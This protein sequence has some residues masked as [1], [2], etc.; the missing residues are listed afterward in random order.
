MSNKRLEEF[1]DNKYSHE[2]KSQDIANIANVAIP[3]NRYEAI[4][5][6]FPQVFK[7]GDIL[8]I[9]AGDGRVAKKLLNSNLP[10]NSYTIS[11]VS[12]VRMQGVQKHMDDERLAILQLDVEDIPSEHEGKYDAIIMIA[13]IEHLIDPLGAMRE[14]RKLLRP[15]SLIYIDTPNIAK[16]TQR[17]RLL[18]GRF[19]ST[20]SKNEGLTTNS[21]EPVELHEMGHL[22]Y[23]TF[24][25]LSL[26]L[27]E[28]CGF[29]S[30]KKFGYPEGRRIFGKTA[31]GA[32][33]KLWPEMFSELALV[34]YA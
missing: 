16:Y 1:Y 27:T 9:G 8:E 30:V 17:I 7:G 23:F 33:A 12:Y 24:R 32:L 34:A 11:D 31:H 25:S 13:L 15:N 14:I 29:S 20:S 4:A 5:K 28:R 22:H 2:L 3:C 10:I 18:Y 19:P 26:M 21:G 6:F